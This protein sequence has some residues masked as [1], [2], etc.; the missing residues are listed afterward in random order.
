[1][2]PRYCV[3]QTLLSFYRTNWTSLFKHSNKRWYQKE[4]E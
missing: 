3:A 1:M 4:K 2:G